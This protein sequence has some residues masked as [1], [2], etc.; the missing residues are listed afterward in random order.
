MKSL[1]FSNQDIAAS[2]GCSR[3]T[4]SRSLT[5]AEEEGLTWEQAQSLSKEQVA[6]RLFGKSRRDKNP[7]DS[8]YLQPDCAWIQRELRK[9]RVSL[10]AL[11][12]QYAEMALAAGKQAYGQTQ[13][14]KIYAE[15]CS[16][17]E[18]PRRK[19]CTPGEV[20]EVGWANEAL[21]YS[22]PT[23][24][25]DIPC[26]LFVAVL[27]YSEYAYAEAMPGMQPQHWLLGHIH[28]Y[29]SF[30][31]TTRVVVPD[32][33]QVITGDK[34][35]RSAYIKLAEQYETA[36]MPTRP[37]K[38][39]DRGTA[40]AEHLVQD[41]GAMLIAA[42]RDRE[43]TSLGGIN[44]SLRELLDQYHHEPWPYGESRVSVFEA[45]ERETLHPLPQAPNQ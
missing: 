43:A 29:A 2:L 38:P 9:S 1:G 16:T 32:N 26:Y 27:P 21:S 11:R 24:G 36:V 44:A 18:G 8:P 34:F 31:G 19:A 14:N 10:K 12:A 40:D 20:L 41:I 25:D 6:E 42:L 15:Y 33:W 13:F 28:A 22:D 37:R 4:V 3:G 5:Q 35:Q 30:G 17:A 7:E 45:E 39:R 23:T